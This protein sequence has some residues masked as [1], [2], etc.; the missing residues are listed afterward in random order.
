MLLPLLWRFF[1]LDAIDIHGHGLRQHPKASYWE[2][3]FD[4]P[5]TLLSLQDNRYSQPA[6]SLPCLL[7][8]LGDL[9]SP[10][11]RIV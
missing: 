9:F 2:I 5:K 6:L 3:K 1:S 11:S 4:I 8:S 10:T 7:E